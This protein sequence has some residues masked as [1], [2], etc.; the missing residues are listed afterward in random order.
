MDSL[1]KRKKQRN[2]SKKEK[3]NPFYYHLYSPLVFY[4][5]ILILGSLYLFLNSSKIQKGAATSQTSLSNNLLNHSWT[6]IDTSSLQS[7]EEDP[8]SSSYASLKRASIRYVEG[9][10]NH[11]I[12]GTDYGSIDLLFAPDCKPDHMVPMI[13]LR[14]HRLNDNTYA[15]NIGIVGR[16]S[17]TTK[18][19]I[20][21]VNA[22]YDFRQGAFGNY[23]GLGLGF[24]MLGEKWDFRAN[25]YFPLGT[26]NHHGT[27]TFDDYFGPYFATERRSLIACFGANAEIGYTAPIKK[28]GLVYL[29]LGPYYFAGA[30]GYQVGGG[31]LRIRP[32]YKDILALDILGS[33]DSRSGANGQIQLIL[34]LPLYNIGSQKERN[35]DCKYGKRTF[36]KPVERFEVMQLGRRSRWRSNF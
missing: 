23:N 30:E 19:Y 25:G 6:G 1:T 29:A 21:G 24:E 31:E 18:P 15:A 34:S 5:C 11:V 7:Y 27:H 35:S 16:Y 4:V 36:Y 33:Y 8:I 9:S 22:Y 14:A 10:D 2:Y 28:E 12:Y 17:S 3:K 32:Q 20:Y 13:D 26:N